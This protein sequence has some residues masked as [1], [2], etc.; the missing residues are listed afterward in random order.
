MCNT[1]W[2]SL[3]APRFRYCTIPFG[4]SPSTVPAAVG[5]AQATTVRTRRELVPG[6]PP[7]AG[8]HAGVLG[9]RALLQMARQPPSAPSWNVARPLVL[10]PVQN[11]NQW[12]TGGVVGCSRLLTKRYLVPT[13]GL[14]WNAPGRQVICLDCIVRASCVGPNSYAWG[15]VRTQIDCSSACL[16]S[17]RL[18]YALV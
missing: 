17:T 15:S 13:S 5:P 1:P 11:R 12:I 16:V 18:L 7:P 14:L 4:I 6:C 8:N 9:D 2:R 3:P 10:Y